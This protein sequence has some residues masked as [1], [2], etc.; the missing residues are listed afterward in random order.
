MPTGSLNLLTQT[1]A[2]EG[3]M[4]PL[5]NDNILDAQYP[6]PYL[7]RTRDLHAS[8]RECELSRSATLTDTFT[9]ANYSSNV[10]DNNTG[11]VRLRRVWDSWSTEYSKR[12]RTGFTTIPPIQ[13]ASAQCRPA[14]WSPWGPLGGTPPIYPSYPAPYQAPLRGIQIQIRVVDPDQSTDQIAHD[15]AGFH[16]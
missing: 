6:N 7:H 1:F 11:V 10:G 12:R 15:P 14:Q 5:I 4:P 13:R 2:H 3:R 9:F 16:G 8:V